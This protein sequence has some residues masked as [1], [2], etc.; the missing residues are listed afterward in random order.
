MNTDELI[1][2]YK[3]YFKYGET[4]VDSLVYGL[5]KYTFD[6]LEKLWNFLNHCQIQT[7]KP[8]SKLKTNSKFFYDFYPRCIVE[9]IEEKLRFQRPYDNIIFITDQITKNPRNLYVNKTDRFSYIVG[10]SCNEKD[11]LFAIESNIKN[12]TYIHGQPNS[13]HQIA[14]NIDFVSKYQ[15]KI[16]GL[17]NTDSPCFVGK[18]FLDKYNIHLNDQMIDW[19]S[20]LNFYTCTFGKKHF[21]PT[22]TKHKNSYRNVVNLCAKNFV[23][24]DFLKVNLNRILCDCGKY[25]CDSYFL[26]H[27]KNWIGHFNY[28][29]VLSWSNIL[30]KE[31]RSFQIIQD[32]GKLNIF[33]RLSSGHVSNDIIQFFEHKL[34]NLT[35]N[36]QQAIK[37][38]A[39]IPAIWNLQNNIFL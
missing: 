37:I 15:D 19:T 10:N 11:F 23:T 16:L 6:D 9:K 32:K 1:Q 33:Y 28:C 3:E 27:K 14:N 35:W 12:K 36:H 4:L 26:P 39:K 18:K 21:L 34:G 29:E 24:S 17:I 20:G 22:F 5:T 8:N 38:G 13:L 7:F 25:R 30:S 31:F 2:L